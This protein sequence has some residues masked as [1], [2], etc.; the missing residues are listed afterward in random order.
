MLEVGQML[1]GSPPGD[2]FDAVKKLKLRHFLSR[3]LGNC[4]FRRLVQACLTG[5]RAQT[6][7]FV[8]NI[9]DSFA[10]HCP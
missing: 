10:V 2:S 4:K 8:T 7:L 3:C 9:V 6:V 5:C 1:A